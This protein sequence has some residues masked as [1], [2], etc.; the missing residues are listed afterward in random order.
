VIEVRDLVA[1]YDDTV[2]LKN[3]SLSVEE[4]E[5]MVIM[6]QSGCGKTT[7]LRCLV[8]LMK[9]ASGEVI[10]DGKN[11]TK[12]NEKQYRELSREFG[13]LFQSGA[14]FNSMR[15]DDNIA[16]PVREHFKLAATIV[17]L[18]VKIKLELVGLGHAGTKM[19]GELSG[20]MKKRA[21][22]ARAMVLDPKILFLDEPTSGLD[23]VI[24][25]GIDDLVL[26]IKKAFHTTM[27]VVSHDVQSGLKIA[28]RIAIFYKG[29]IVQVGTPDEIQNSS[30]SYVQQFMNRQPPTEEETG[31]LAESL[32]N[33]V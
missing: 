18:M 15:L 6:G 23:P 26:K 19:P 1:K 11:M 33:H 27:V 25:A 30:N 7:F 16:F 3:I 8:G 32:M 4:G 13:M 2:V 22:L 24:A 5:T 31:D 28:D 14:L 10:V 29:E 21:G 9:P 20:G 12:L 17:R